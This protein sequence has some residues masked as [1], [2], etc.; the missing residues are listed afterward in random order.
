MTEPSEF[1]LLQT[2]TLIDFDVTNQEI[3]TTVDKENISVKVKLQFKPEEDEDPEDIVEWGALGFIFAIAAQSFNDARPR[4]HSDIDYEEDEQLT[5]S[6]L[7][8]GLTFV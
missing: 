2:G 3:Q 1:K 6:D 5:V 7:I 8:E 4:G